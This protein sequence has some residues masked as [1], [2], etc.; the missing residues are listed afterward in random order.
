MKIRDQSAVDLG[1]VV[2]GACLLAGTGLRF[3]HL[4][5]QSLWIDELFSVV[6]SH[7]GVSVPEIVATYSTDV[8]PLGYPL[9]LHLWLE[10]FGDTASAAR[11]LSAVFGVL[12]IAAVF[13][14]GRSCFHPLTGVFAAVMTSVNAFHI[15]Y[16]QEARSYSLVFFLA[17]LS[18]WAFLR[19]IAR[20]GWRTALAYGMATAAA[21]HVHYYAYLLAFGQVVAALFAGGLRRWGWRRLIPLVAGA[22]G[23]GLTTVV[24]LRSILKVAK[25][26]EYWP[27]RPEPY[28]LIEYFHQYFGS[29]LILSVTCGGLL[30]ALP[31]LIFRYSDPSRSAGGLDD[32]A[33]AGLLVGSLVVS[34]TAAYLRSILVVPMLIPR[35]TII[36]LPALLL[37][38]G[39]SLSKLKPTWLSVTVVSGLALASVAGL[40]QTGYYSTPSKEQWR[41]AVVHLL[42]DPRLND[43]TDLCLGSPA[44]GFQYYVDQLGGRVTLKD[45]ELMEL[46]EALEDRVDRPAVWLLVARDERVV[47]GLR[48]ELR[49]HWDRTDRVVYL[50]TSVE[51]WEPLKPDERDE[52]GNES[53][54]R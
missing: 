26:D 16:S 36:F 28:F 2:L 40:F 15:A 34:L 1:F 38:I 6:F 21:M 22:V 17:T 20:P 11:G 41:E 47:Q 7:P 44:L 52:G 12:G 19:V 25:M 4:D 49:R 37:L 35:V 18:Y 48:R 45:A 10:V 29:D 9:A 3:Y 43:E 32:G 39:L 13:F 8:H 5:F 23:A 51:R 30:V 54:Q 46:A 42:S 33:K 14:A 53:T 50:K 24:W 27:A 31:F